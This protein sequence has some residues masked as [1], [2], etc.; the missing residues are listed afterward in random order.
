M[1]AMTKSIQN[2]RGQQHYHGIQSRDHVDTKNEKPQHVGL[3]LT[4]DK[5]DLNRIQCLPTT[6]GRDVAYGVRSFFRDDDLAMR[7]RK[8]NAA[9][10]ICQIKN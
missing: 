3:N 4:T 5:L 2:I 1:C 9:Q 7:K 6:D 10:T 8:C